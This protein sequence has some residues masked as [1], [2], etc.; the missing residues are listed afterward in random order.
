MTALY[1]AHAHIGTTEELTLRKKQNILSL[2]CATDPEEVKQL[3]EVAA[4]SLPLCCCP[5]SL[6]TPPLEGGSN[7]LPGHGT[8]A[9]KGLCHR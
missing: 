8:V 2:I 7:I 4:R 6:W 5:S 9:F 3:E 1:D